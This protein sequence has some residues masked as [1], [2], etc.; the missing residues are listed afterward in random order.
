MRRRRKMNN[1]IRK[2][3]AFEILNHWVLATSCFVLIVSGFAFLFHL[4]QLGYLFGDFNQM[5]LV[6]NWAGVV[7]GIS[8]LFTMMHYL[9]VSLKFG[10][11]DFGWMLKGGGYLSK[12]VKVPPQDE[13]NAG[14]KLYYLVVL[15]AGIAIS[16]SGFVIWLRPAVPDITRYVLLSHLVHNVSFD[17]M[18]IAI[19]AHIYLASLANP[20]TF[21]IMVYGTVPLEWARKRHEK[22]VKRMGY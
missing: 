13:L 5:K 16:A 18:V 21:R 2:A 15:I 20:G 6:H 17:L 8:L 11:D 14:Q 22:W 12:K 3:S 4:E 1:M 10:A 19:P 9:P 7:F